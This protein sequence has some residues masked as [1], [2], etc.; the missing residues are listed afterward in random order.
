[1]KGS[2]I[3]IPRQLCT[4]IL[5]KIHEGLMGIVKCCHWAQ[6]SVWWANIT[7]EITSV[8]EDCEQC[9]N[10]RSQHEEPLQPTTLPGRL[11]S[12][13]GM[14]IFELT[15][16]HYLVVQDYFSRFLVVMKLDR[17]SSEAE[18]LRSKK[19]DPNLGLLACR[20]IASESGFS[21]VEIMF[22]WKLRITLPQASS[23]QQPHWDTHSFRQFRTCDL[24]IKER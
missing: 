21:P 4:D 6:E 11:W 12:L 24:C 18:I 9:L 23:S 15:N 3:F 8:V 17:L 14:D 22:G 5:G 16:V 19:M 13:I 10:Q 7:T 2:R 1:M 20:A